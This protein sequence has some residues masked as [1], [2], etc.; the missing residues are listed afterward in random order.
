MKYTG[1]QLKL[2]LLQLRWYLQSWYNVLMITMIIA[3]VTDHCINNQWTHQHA[4]TNRPVHKF[5]LKISGILNFP[6][7]WCFYRFSTASSPAASFKHFQFF[8]SSP[9]L[10]SIALNTRG[11]F[12]IFTRAGQLGNVKVSFSCFCPNKSILPSFLISYQFP[13][14][15]ISPSLFMAASCPCIHFPPSTFQ[16]LSASAPFPPFPPQPIFTTISTSSTGHPLF[17]YGMHQL[18]HDISAKFLSVALDHPL[19]QIQLNLYFSKHLLHPCTC[20]W[21]DWHPHFLQN[22][23][24]CSVS[25]SSW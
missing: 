9:L 20:T 25:T 10:P 11:C 12:L 7:L 22:N 19:I 13:T 15:M 3:A 5:F 14:V 24:L 21:L 6:Q 8:P 1:K 18:H 4:K 23:K 16:P 17:L 2:L